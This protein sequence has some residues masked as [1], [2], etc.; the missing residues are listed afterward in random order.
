MKHTTALKITLKF[1]LGGALGVLL[2]P[3][4]AGCGNNTQTASN[5]A[6]QSGATETSSENQTSAPDTSLSGTIKG[7]GSST[8]FP[9]T[10]AIAEEFQA[11]YPNVKVTV[12]VSGTGGGFKKFVAGE[13]AIQNASRQIKP[14]ESALAKKNGVE[15]IEL[16]IAYDGLSVVVNPK[17]D[18]AKCLTTAQLKKI[19][20]T[21]SKVNNWNQIDPKFP[22]RP[23]KL[24]GAGTDSGTFD[25]FTEAVNGE[26]GRSR[27]DYTASE[28]DNS[29]VQGVTRDVNAMGYFGAAYYEENADKLKGLEID[30]GNG[31]VAMTPENVASNK[32]IPFSRPMFIYVNRKDADKPEI[33]AFMKFAMEKAPEL[34]KQVGYVPLPNDL[35]AAATRRFEARTTGTVYAN[36]A[37]KAKPL[38]ELFK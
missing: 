11:Q 24:Y 38:S 12:G 36:E 22:N 30:G 1:V 9:I 14:E 10:E 31:C 37:N 16:P 2:L 34:V 7:D 35:Y 27:S 5:D 21:G 17:N 23:L 25:Y 3:T 6:A 13:T 4:L 32:Y 29:L 15:Y 18:W 28:D 8:V 20:D 33:K 19:W 26:G